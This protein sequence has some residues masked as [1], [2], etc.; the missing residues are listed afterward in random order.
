MKAK[1]LHK[2]LGIPLC[3]FLFFAALSGILLNHRDL[4]QSVDIPRSVLPRSY[5]FVG[6]NNGAVRGVLRSDSL[7][8]IYGSAGVWVTDSS[9]RSEAKPLGAGFVPGADEAKIMSMARDSAGGVWVASQY[10]LYKLSP[11]G[12]RWVEQPLPSSVHGRLADLQISGD[13]V[14]LLSRSLLYRR[15]LSSPEWTTYELKK[16]EGYTGKILLFQIVWALHSGEY[17]GL[18]GRIIVDL[19]GLLVMILSLTGIFYTFL[20]HRLEAKKGQEITKKEEDRKHRLAKKLSTNFKWHK[21]VGRKT[22][23]AVLFVFVTGWVLRPPL[24][25]PLV[26]TKAQP[27][28]FSSLYS[29]NPWFDR[30]RAIR[31]DKHQGGWLLSTS[32]GFFKLKD[33]SAVPEPWELQPQVSPMGINGFAQRAD[34]SWLVGSFTGLFEVHPEQEESIRNYFTGESVG[35]VTMGPPVGS[36]TISGLLAGD[37][38]KEDLVFLYD[39]GV[40]G[41]TDIPGE[42]AKPFPFAPQPEALNESPYSLWQAALE[43]HAGRLYQPFLG[44]W[45][46]ALFIFFL[47]LSSVIVLI[48]GLKRRSPKKKHESS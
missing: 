30:L 28:R 29:D 3:F 6:W 21:A 12:S 46:T 23:Y 33:F 26:F 5:Q 38:P 8:Y 24:M 31:Q 16:P 25:L 13:S 45:G 35:E 20:R 11:E 2:Y 15:S 4:L 7:A 40:V 17:F 48:T 36:F 44:T 37:N 47:G 27:N 1:K 41:R 39:R 9:L 19:L 18:V 14:L 32:E 43:L 22:F 34:G 10:R 42:E